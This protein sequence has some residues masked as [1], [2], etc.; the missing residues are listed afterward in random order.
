MDCKLTRRELLAGLS[1]TVC[2]AG[3]LSAASTD[4]VPLIPNNEHSL[5]RVRIT[6]GIEGNAK[7]PKSELSTDA[8]R[9][10]PVK[11]DSVIDYEER[12]HR[13]GDGIAQAAQRYYYEA[14]TKGKVQTNEVE[15]E[16]RRESRHAVLHVAQTRSIV[17]AAQTQLTTDELELLKVPVNSLAIDRLLPNK[18]MKVNEAW[19]IESDLLATLFDM[20]AVQKSAVSATLASFDDATA[21]V[22]LLGTISA[23]VDGV[24]TS[25]QLRGKLT[26]DRK[27][28]TVTWLALAIREERGLSKA[29]PGFEVAAQIRVIRQAIT[30]SNGIDSGEPIDL[31]IKPTQDKLLVDIR[32][33]QGGFS[34]F[35][36]RNWH[37]ISE[38]ERFAQLRMIDN[39]RVI[40]QCDIRP[41]PKLKD[42]HQLTLE[43]FQDDIRRTLDKRFNELLEAE[44]KVTS[45]GLR[46]LRVVAQG[47]VEEVPVQWIYLHFSDDQGHRSAAIFTLADQQVE[48]FG[49]GDHQFAEGFR[50]TPADDAETKRVA[51]AS[52][53]NAPANK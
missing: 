21:K 23:S 35:C 50:F 18:S 53:L 13:D 2:A 12:L 20:D 14:T 42:G 40:A 43:A 46:L 4:T 28:R 3:P 5:Y 39:D 6:V 29:K 26:F 51:S 25:L 48:A 19:E 15:S 36:D 44:E 45:G 16:L 49:G 33:K 22:Q 17:Y 11:A 24:P 7:V 52:S 9:K 8:T 32:S 30:K 1:L 10:L 37:L 41:M 38:N 47:A 31:A 34:V 27:Q